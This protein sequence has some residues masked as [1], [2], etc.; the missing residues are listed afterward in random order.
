MGRRV[1]RS[2]SF[3]RI[4]EPGGIPRFLISC[5]YCEAGTQVTSKPALGWQ[6]PVCGSGF[7]LE[8]GTMIPRE[9]QES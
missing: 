2:A 7:N 6:C 8:C 5:N 9:D 4:R 3:A 1:R